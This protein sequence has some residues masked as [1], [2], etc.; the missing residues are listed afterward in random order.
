MAKI[1]LLYGILFDLVVSP[2]VSYS[3][4]RLHGFVRFDMHQHKHT[5]QVV[6]CR[7]LFV[8]C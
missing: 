6:S 1:R 2:V 8:K 3:S 4:E 5:T 7:I